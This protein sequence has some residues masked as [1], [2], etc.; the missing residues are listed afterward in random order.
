MIIET[1]IK[2]IENSEFGFFELN[3]KFLIHTVSTSADNKG[4][5]IYFK[6]INENGVFDVYD[7]F[8]EEN[9]LTDY[10][11]H[12]SKDD[13]RN[14]PNIEFYTEKFEK[15]K[16]R[17]IIS[18]KD[19][20]I[21]YSEYSVDEIIKVKTLINNLDNGYSDVAFNIYLSEL[22]K[23]NV[24]RYYNLSKKSKQINGEFSTEKYTTY[25]K[26]GNKGKGETVHPLTSD[27]FN[28]IK[29]ISKASKFEK[30][31]FLCNENLREHYLSKVRNALNLRRNPN[32]TIHTDFV[33][34][35]VLQIAN[36]KKTNKKVKQKKIRSLFVNRDNEI[37]ENFIK[38]KQAFDNLEL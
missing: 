9:I 6:K 21:S 10:S 17:R 20:V 35:A 33:I 32:G 12:I 8:D 36:A 13:L 27:L 26:D 30:E 23:H 25:D 7:E 5:A 37:K 15:A 3:N 31:L 24:R 2:S 22:K 29:V 38:R 4:Y 14:E 11:A 18:D 1:L 28:G 16:K 19:A 34:R